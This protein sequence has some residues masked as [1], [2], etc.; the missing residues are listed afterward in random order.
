MDSTVPYLRTQ[1]E[2]LAEIKIL[3]RD[4]SATR[5][6][7]VEYYNALNGVLQTWHANVRYPHIYTITDGWQAG[8]FGYTLPVYVRPPL[9]PQLLRRVPFDEYAIESTTSTWQ[10]V[11]GWEVEPDGTGTLVLRLHASPRT[12]EGRVIFYAPNGRVPTTIPT[13]SGS[14][15]DT[16]TSLLIGTAIDVD[17]VG[18]IKV[19][20]EYMMYAGVTR[21]SATTTLLNLVRAQNGS[22]AATH[23]SASNVTWCVAMDDLRLHRLLM[24]QWRSFLHEYFIQDGGVHERSVHEKAMGYHAQLAATFWPTYK[25]IRKSAGLTLSR[26]QFIL[27]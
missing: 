1:A 27:R 6:S 26:K 5:W 14:T 16:A 18:Y 8:T 10:D 12:V 13:S 9:H 15:S 3:V 24:D 21:G 20:A 19:N 4:T 7:N 17:E 22:T 23:N 2:L 25:P 11:P